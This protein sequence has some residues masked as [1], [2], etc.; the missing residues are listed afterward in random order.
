MGRGSRLET[1]LAV[2]WV[3]DENSERSSG[4]REPEAGGGAAR[5]GRQP[6]ERMGLFRSPCGL[7]NPV[8][9][10]RLAGGVTLGKFQLCLSLSFLIEE[11]GAKPTHHAGVTRKLGSEGGS[12]PWRIRAPG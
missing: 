10:P 3:S 5:G 7:G 6:E 4:W 9:Q 2:L 11:M 1:K 12:G 8:L